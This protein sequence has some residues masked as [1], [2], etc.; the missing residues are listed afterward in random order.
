[1]TEIY[2]RFWKLERFWSV[3]FGKYTLARRV[4]LLTIMGLFFLQ[5][6]RVKILMGGLTGSLIFRWINFLDI[7]AL[8]ES[9]LSS[10]SFSLAAFYAAVPILILY[11]LLGRVF[12]GWVC[13]LDLIFRL[14]DKVKRPPQL[15]PSPSRWEGWEGGLARKG[16]LAPLGFLILA[17]FAEV[18]IFSSHLSPI[19]NFY[20]TLYA[21]F[22]WASGFPGEAVILAVSALILLGFLLLE[23]FWPRLWCRAL[24]PVGKTYGLFNGVSLLRLK[25]IERECLNCR[26]CEEVCYMGVEILS[27]IDRKKI[28][29]SSCILCGRC[30]EACNAHGKI[31]KMGFGR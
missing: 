20:R 15:S 29:D 22:F 7:F 16:Y 24:C 31:L 13:P 1:M 2:R 19:T 27:Q 28:R 18:P 3:S 14:I 25:F 21:G 12:C 30:V 6:F 8:M 10:R 11:L 5:L 9:A 26:G 17:F 23:F 4:V